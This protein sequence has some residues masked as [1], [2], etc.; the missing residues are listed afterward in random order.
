MTPRP[1]RRIPH[2][3]QPPGLRRQIQAIIPPN[4]HGPIQAIELDIPPRHDRVSILVRLG[5]NHRDAPHGLRLAPKRARPDDGE[6]RAVDDGLAL[7]DQRRRVVGVGD[8]GK[9]KGLLVE[10]QG[11]GGV[12]VRDEGVDG[13][14]VVEPVVGEVLEVGFLEGAD[15][16]GVGARE[17]LD[18]GFGE[19]AVGPVVAVRAAELGVGERWG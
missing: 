10:G 11:R 1:T 19:A 7:E 9:G 18:L 13:L 5:L 16:A 15:E 17:L 3:P 6:A 8:L 14:G 12:G 4:I 2:L